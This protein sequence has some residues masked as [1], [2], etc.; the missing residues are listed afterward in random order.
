M[1]FQ[2]LFKSSDKIEETFRP[3][4]DIVPELISIH[5]PKTAGTS[6]RNT[7]KSVYGEKSVIR[8]DI[9]LIKHELRINEV[10]Y[11]HKF[12]PE[13][14]KVVHGHFSLP[15]LYTHLTVSKNVPVITWLRDPV[16]RV[17]SNY[18][19]LS[20]RL[21][22]ELDEHGK[23]INILSKLQR[24]LREY[25]LYEPHQNRISKFLNGISL[26]D[27][28]FVGFVEEYDQCLSQLAQKLSWADYTY[29]R[30]NRTGREFI[31]EVN[32]KELDLIAEVNADDLALYKEA[33]ELYRQGYWI[34]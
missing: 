25:A 14:T 1:L 34:K 15:D 8:L 3:D 9:G 6:F 16:K 17:V 24:S 21:H 32:Q 22:E 19:Y 27:L 5:I 26:R 28:Y 18:F 29:Y 10:V 2:K 31:S 33:Q 30:Q 11:S 12:L 23:G 7:L 20:K 13:G 4:P